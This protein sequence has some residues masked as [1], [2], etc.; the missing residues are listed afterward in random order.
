MTNCCDGTSEPHIFVGIFVLTYF[1]CFLYAP[2]MFWMPKGFYSSW[3]CS[4]CFTF[5]P[6]FSC[7]RPD[8]CRETWKH[9]VRKRPWSALTLM[10]C[11]SPPLDPPS[12][13]SCISLQVLSTT[14]FRL[15]TVHLDLCTSTTAWALEVL[16]HVFACTLWWVSM[17][18]ARTDVL[19]SPA[20]WVLFSSIF[21]LFS[22]YHCPAMVRYDCALCFTCHAKLR[23]SLSCSGGAKAKRM[24][25]W[26]SSFGKLAAQT[27]SPT[28]L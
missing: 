13:R 7:R 3:F 17:L 24:G 11:G 25:M 18:T 9:I 26:N 15:S 5:L 20:G 1:F 28:C 16:N 23:L 14:L 6:L 4:R 8:C 10:R 27:V 19:F 2:L 22:F 21:S 12:I